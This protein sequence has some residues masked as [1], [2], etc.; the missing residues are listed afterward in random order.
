MTAKSPSGRVNYP[1][2]IPDDV[3]A[4]EREQVLKSWHT[5]R[6]VDLNEAVAFHRTLPK[7]KNFA[8]TI[9]AAHKENRTLLWPRTG[10]ARI[11]AHIDDL[12]ELER[13][14]AELSATTADSYTRTQR[15]AQADE[16]IAESEKLG[17]S[18]LNGL[19]VVS[20]GVER[21][22]CVV[23][24]TGLANQFRTGTPDARLSNE[25]IMAAG[26]RAQQGGMLGT[27]LPFIKELP[28]AEAVR[29]WQYVERVMGIYQSRGIDVHRE[30]YGALM[31][32]IMPPSIMCASLIFDG[33][34]GAEQGVK[35]ITLGANNNLHVLQDVA[36]LR[37]LGKLA[38][39]Y[40]A[41][42]GFADVTITPLLYM[43]MGQFPH[44]EADSYS[45]IAQGAMTAVLGG[46]AAVVVK[47][48]DE[49]FGI[50]S[51]ASNALSTRLTRSI[52]E[53]TRQ[54]RYPDSDVL[55][56]EMEMI[57]RE[58]RAIVDTAIQLGDSD[59]STG[60]VR[61]YATGV[62]DVPF[63]PA[64]GNA[65]KA[66]PVRDANG[67]VRFLEFG[68]LPFDEDIKAY[69]RARVAARM[70][71]E[72]AEQAAFKM[73]LRDVSIEAFRGIELTGAAA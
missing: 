62:M 26:F 53:L 23:E 42:H 19:P 9:A 39:E 59:I 38:R 45:L 52:L 50:P 54:Q 46:A 6:D 57:E 13:S 27:S 5:G 10:Q 64:V 36:A 73:V 15:Y 55:R 63:A 25:I 41:K 51:T 65:G 3:F 70:K 33:L 17:R 22:R 14:G 35:H 20:L 47:T 61:A 4:A 43:W 67:A 29:N 28:I 40:F 21:T 34:M 37:V 1:G 68:S 71:R 31:G 7:A 58:T 32:M 11:D 2:R 8:R 12:N 69:H 56:D 60:V 44:A 30:Y 66:L 72:A 24:R 16:A 18:L 49:A 48:P